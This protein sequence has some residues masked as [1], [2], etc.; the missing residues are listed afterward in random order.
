V[1]VI[2]PGHGGKGWGASMANAKEKDI[3]LDIAL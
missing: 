3:V 2:D 1:V